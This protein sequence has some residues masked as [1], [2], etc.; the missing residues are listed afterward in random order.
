MGFIGFRPQFISPFWVLM[1]VSL[2]L[3]GCNRQRKINLEEKV[4]SSLDSVDF[5]FD[6]SKSFKIT[7][8]NLGKEEL[9]V[10]HWVAGGLNY[11]NVETML[12]SV[13]DSAMTETEKAFALWRFVSESGFHYSYPYNHNLKDNLDPVSLVTFP[14][15]LCGEKSGILANLAHQAGLK[16]RVITMDGHIVTEIFCDGSWSMFDAD[17]NVVFVTSSRKPFAI[18]QLSALPD[19]I[20]KENIIKSVDDKFTGFKHYQTYMKGYKP[21]SKWISEDFLIRNYFGKSMGIKLFPSDSI[22]FELIESSY[23]KRFVHRRYKFETY[24]FIYRHIQESQVKIQNGKETVYLFEDTI[25][26]Y[27]KSILITKPIGVPIEAYLTVQNRVSGKLDT[28]A[29]GKVGGKEV[30]E[31][32]FNAPSDSCIY[33][34]YQLVSKNCDLNETSRIGIK[35]GFEF[36]QLVFPYSEAKQIVVNKVGGGE[37]VIHAEAFQ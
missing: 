29:K 10:W 36:N 17:E 37:L 33:Y 26:Y 11:F 24:G 35:I 27:I 18:A 34:S 30:M 31:A 21:D 15:F 28:V 12:A 32:K 1:L 23:F 2:V 7:Y 3:L 14:Y 5:Q 13:I 22:S 19:L 9:S 25:P 8:A 16:T 20:C 6:H 4:S